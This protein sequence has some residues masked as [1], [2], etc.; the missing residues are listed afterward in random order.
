MCLLFIQETDRQIDYHLHGWQA[1]RQASNS[2]R[3]SNS[4]SLLLL[5]LF[6]HMLLWCYSRSSLK[7]VEKLPSSLTGHSACWASMV[8]LGAS[9]QNPHWGSSLSWSVWEGDHPLTF[10]H[11]L[12]KMQWHSMVVHQC[13]MA[14][15]F[16]TVAS[17]LGL[18]SGE[19]VDDDV[20][21]SAWPL[22]SL[23]AA[24]ASVSV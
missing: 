4:S 20:P 14:C 23:L 8:G 7:L 13:T 21:F 17:N 10:F 18:E 2:R 16:N 3:Y 12:L 24:G 15:V 22:L 11:L 6:L 5:L 9:T 19:Y 1:G